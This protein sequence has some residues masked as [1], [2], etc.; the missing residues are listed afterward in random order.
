MPV[1]VVIPLLGALVGTPCS[2]IVLSGVDGSDSLK[3][4][5][6]GEQSPVALPQSAVEVVVVVLVHAVLQVGVAVPVLALVLVLWDCAV[7]ECVCVC[8]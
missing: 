6:G 8:V 4:T 3:V 5:I 2:C 1:G 7:C